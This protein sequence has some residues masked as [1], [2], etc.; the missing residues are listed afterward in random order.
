MDAK[1]ICIAPGC[2]TPRAYDKLCRVHFRRKQAG[3]LKINQPCRAPDCDRKCAGFDTYCRAHMKNMLEHG[4]PRVVR[5]RRSPYSTA[6]ANT[7]RYVRVGD[8]TMA[9]HRVVME[10]HLGRRLVEGENVHHLNG[11][12]YDNRIEN[13]ELWSTSQPAGQRIQDKVHW[14]KQLLAL[15]EPDALA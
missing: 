14:A 11:A 3:E 2:N 15:Y 5:R 7:Y 4:V 9:E 8:Q 10:R 12:R 13:L 6:E 1:R